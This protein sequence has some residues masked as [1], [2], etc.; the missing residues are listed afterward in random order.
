VRSNEVIVISRLLR[1]PRITIK[2]TKAIT[3]TAVIFLADSTLLVI[4]SGKKLK[5]ESTVEL[6]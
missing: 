2:V 5:K 3:I 6:K 4:S 1:L